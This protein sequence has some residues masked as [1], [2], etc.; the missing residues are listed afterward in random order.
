MTMQYDVKQAHTNQSGILVPYSTRVKAVAFVGSTSAGQFVLF[1]TTTAPVSASV[2]YARSGN[3]V[4]V[5]K[6]AHGL[7][8]GDKIGIDYDSG[9]GGS[10]TPGNYIVATASANSF[11][12][13]DLNSGTITGTPAAVYSTGGWLMTFDVAAN[14][15]YNNGSSTMPGEGLYA[16]NGV[17]AY[18]VNLA[19]VS[20]FYG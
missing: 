5:S 18:M 8:A 2:T 4:T 13:T 7:L 19:A 1:D 17:Y 20:V 11:T 16:R 3:T 12:I 6:T 15:I 14:D 9:S 10:A